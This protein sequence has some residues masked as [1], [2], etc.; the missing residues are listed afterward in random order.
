VQASVVTPTSNAAPATSSLVARE[1]AFDDIPRSVWDRLLAQTA[2]ATPFSRWS[3]HR[4][5]WDAYGANAH[6]QYLVITGADDTEARAIAPLMH[7]H[8]VEAEDLPTH[9][10]VREHSPT[11][12]N[13]DG[14]QMAI[15]FGASYHADYATILTAPRDADAAADAMAVAFAG[16]DAR[17]DGDQP[18]DVIDLRRLRMNDPALP[19]L[20]S[21]LD[22]E[23]EQEDVCPVV[24]VRGSTWDEYLATLDKK[25]R[26]EIRRKLRRATTIG[27]LSIEI[28]PPTPDAVGD[29]VRLHTLRFGERGLFPANEGGE[30]S[31][32][33]I[34]RLAELELAEPGGGQLHV[35]RVHCG[36]KLIFT[37]LA[38]DDGQTCYLYNAGMDPDAALASPGVT[39]FALYIR[40]RI[41]AGRTRFDF[42]RG[43]EKYKYEWGA[44]D[45]PVY[46]LLV[47]RG[48][49][50]A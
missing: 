30:R 23:R 21:A 45:E 20:E 14:E 32:R 46:R 41:E 9:T 37:A 27:D 47:Q 40:D 16:N 28:G 36:Q 10:T 11:C 50:A 26:H 2:A 5:W 34:N 49:G 42:L 18:W 22:A 13:V 15:M 44:I 39:G 7:R 25:D 12:R 48:R 1:V 6:E 35:A 31:R 29:F 4:A 38:F 19:A 24:T 3:F 33:F 8:E 43:N 17:F